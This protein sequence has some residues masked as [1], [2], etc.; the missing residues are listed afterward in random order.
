[1]RPTSSSLFPCRPGSKPRLLWDPK[2]FDVRIELGLEREMIGQ[3]EG[4]FVDPVLEFGDAGLQG[5]EAGVA[6]LVSDVLAQPAPQRLDRQEVGAV[7]RQRPA[8]D[9]R[10]GCRLAHAAGAVIADAVP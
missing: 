10:L 9:V 8:L 3:S 6:V 5:V 2:F 7:G 4:V 1:M